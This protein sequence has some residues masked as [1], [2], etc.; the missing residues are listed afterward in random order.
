MKRKFVILLL[1]ILAIVPTF[2]ACGGKSI[3]K[4]DFADSKIA[5]AYP[6]YIYRFVDDIDVV[7]GYIIMDTEYKKGDRFSLSRDTFG[8]IIEV[9]K[10]YIPQV[11]DNGQTY[12]VTYFEGYIGIFSSQAD[13][14][15]AVEEKTVEVEKS[16]VTIYYK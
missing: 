15:A 7:K 4:I 14:E 5:D 2:S 13:A 1:V 16:N 3:S 9:V 12:I 8:N 11:K 6:I 10:E